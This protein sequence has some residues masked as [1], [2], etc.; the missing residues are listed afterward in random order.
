MDDGE[1][2]ALA[3]RHLLE[4][5]HTHLIMVTEPD[6]IHS[7]QERARGFAEALR[8]AD[9]DVVF[10]EAAASDIQ[11]GVAAGERLLSMSPRPTA[12]FAANDLLAIG[13]LQAA[14]H[15]GVRVPADLSVVGF[16]G[17]VMADVTQPPLTTVVQPMRA[18][19]R[20][21]A[22]LLVETLQNGG[23]SRRVVM[24]PRLRVAGTT[25]AHLA[26]PSTSK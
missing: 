24:S 23:E 15:A 18:M 5:G 22:R 12:V 26:A 6:G 10:L 21:A 19:G 1:G 9:V 4:L 17:T 20:A 11:A 13:I 25:A 2:G 16:D 3:A 14:R 8:D 7:S